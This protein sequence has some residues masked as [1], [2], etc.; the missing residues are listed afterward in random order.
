[1]ITEDDLWHP[2]ARRGRPEDRTVQ[3]T[4]NGNLRIF[5]PERGLC[6]TVARPFG[7]LWI[8]SLLLREPSGKIGLTA[9]LELGVN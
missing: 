5:D 8:V 1:M 2:N 9:M 3:T 7:P 4:A 6:M